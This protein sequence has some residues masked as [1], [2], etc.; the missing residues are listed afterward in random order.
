MEHEEKSKRRYAESKRRDA[1]GF[2]SR[3]FYFKF[4]VRKNI[5]FILV[6]FL[7]VGLV[8]PVQFGS[9]QSVSDFRNQTGIFL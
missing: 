7:S 5:L 4:R 3:E 1:V 6:F 9:V 8:E 2:V